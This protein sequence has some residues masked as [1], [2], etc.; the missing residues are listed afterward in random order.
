[1]TTE[2]DGDVTPAL[3]AALAGPCPFEGVHDDGHGTPCVFPRHEGPHSFEALSA[4]IP[5]AITR[6]VIAE[7]ERIAGVAAALGAHYHGAD[8]Q[9][10]PF[11]DLLWGARA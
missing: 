6:A 1:M 3:G 11:A 9:S 7:K 8:G 4:P 2:P 10:A 5:P